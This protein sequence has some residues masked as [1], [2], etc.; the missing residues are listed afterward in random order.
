MRAAALLFAL[1]LTSTQSDVRTLVT[2]WID[3]HQ[4]Q[5]LEELIEL[6]SIPNIAANRPDIRRNA[7]R[8]EQMLSARGFRAELLETAGNPLVYGELRVPGASRT[9][10]LYC[11]Y[12]GQPVDPAQ[13]K[14]QSPFT[15]VL[16]RGRLQDQAATVDLAAGLAPLCALRVRRQIS[17][18][19]RSRGCR[20]VEERRTSAYLE[21]PHRARR[22]GGSQLAEPR[23][24][25]RSISRPVPRR[26][27][28]DSGRPDALERTSHGCLRRAGSS[29]GGPDGLRP[30]QR[31]SQRQLRQLDSES[32]AAAF[33]T[34]RLDEGR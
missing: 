2:S 8:L 22:R 3:A 32:C 4:K 14:Q 15:P 6:L 17:D 23:A 34:A 30:D 1:V 31:R 28:A 20:R 29:H 9:L 10:L 16:R 5:V 26:S 18:R 24:R 27:D 13:W 12:D 25:D 33:A 21:R 7:E 19:R 11:H